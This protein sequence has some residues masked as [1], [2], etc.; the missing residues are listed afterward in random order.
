[1]LAQGCRKGDQQTSR[2]VGQ[3]DISFQIWQ[4]ETWENVENVKQ[5]KQRLWEKGEALIIPETTN[6]FKKRQ[7]RN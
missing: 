7:A 1:M 6:F 4:W 3:N 2:A 5:N